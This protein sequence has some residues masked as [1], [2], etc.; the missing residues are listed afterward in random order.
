MRLNAHSI[1][2]NAQFSRKPFLIAGLTLLTPSV[3]Y[4]RIF[5]L[6]EATRTPIQQYGTLLVPSQ[7]YFSFAAFAGELILFLG[8]LKWS[9]LPSLLKKAYYALAINAAISLSSALI[10]LFHLY[11]ATSG[12]SLCTLG[13]G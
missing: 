10:S 5:E 11:P 2:S 6:L 3:F 1:Q 7:V 9:A 13:T 12:S 8:L 4:S